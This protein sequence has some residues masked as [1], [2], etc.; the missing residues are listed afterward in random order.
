MA[1][2][3]KAI[4]QAGAEAFAAWAGVLE[5]R[6]LQ[7]GIAPARARRLAQLAIAAIEGALLQVRVERSGKP[8]A[9]AAAELAAMFAQ[10]VEAQGAQTGRRR[11]LPAA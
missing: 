6:L 11:R 2:E 1:P 9:D 3:N 7:D 10:A 5:A 4:R 8:L